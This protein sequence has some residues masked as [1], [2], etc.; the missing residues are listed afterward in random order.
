MHDSETISINR[1]LNLVFKL[2]FGFYS[3]HVQGMLEYP[4]GITLIKIYLI[5]LLTL[6][7]ESLV[8]WNSLLFV[9]VATK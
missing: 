3:V 1:L 4:I 5:L 9:H 7:C 2:S 6:Q 8:C